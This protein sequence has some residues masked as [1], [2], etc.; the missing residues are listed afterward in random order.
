M[1]HAPLSWSELSCKKADCLQT[2]APIGPGAPP[3][4]DDGSACTV[5]TYDTSAA[6]C[7]FTET[8]DAPPA[9]CYKPAGACGTDGEC[10]YEHKCPASGAG[11]C[12]QMV[13]GI[14][15]ANGCEVRNRSCQCHQM[16][17]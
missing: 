14:C 17:S 5:D 6:E 16:T 4:C 10:A 7:V 9:G 11:A 3:V 2:T 12:Q 13:E 1:A 15:G 8:C